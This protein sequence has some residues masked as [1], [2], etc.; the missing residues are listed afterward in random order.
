MEATANYNLTN[1]ISTSAKVG[2]QQQITGALG[3]G[4]I[5]WKEISGNKLSFYGKGKSGPLKVLDATITI[6]ITGP[7]SARVTLTGAQK[8]TSNA[9]LVPGDGGLYFVGMTGMPLGIDEFWLARA[10][11]ET[12]FSAKKVFW[13]NFWIKPITDA[14][15]TTKDLASLVGSTESPIAPQRELIK[16]TAVFGP[17]VG[18]QGTLECFFPLDSMHTLTFSGNSKS[19]AIPSMEVDLVADFY[20]NPWRA[21]GDAVYS[22][23]VTGMYVTIFFVQDES[24]VAIAV[25][26]IKPFGNDVQV[27]GDG[28]FLIAH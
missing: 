15:A 24:V 22:V 11:V 16:G 28:K 7:T 5:D 18:I 19:A 17:E 27:D 20:K 3:D 13:F 2:V 4:T 12:R 10:G 9:R 8:G 14:V 1:V 25:G 23:H 6:E 26:Q 21:E